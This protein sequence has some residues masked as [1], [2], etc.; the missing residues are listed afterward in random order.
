MLDYENNTIL[1][2]VAKKWRK[3]TN[4]KACKNCKNQKSATEHKKQSIKAVFSGFYIYDF[5]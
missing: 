2:E 5:S 4:K 1:S 3:I